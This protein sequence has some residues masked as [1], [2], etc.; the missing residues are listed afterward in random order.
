MIRYFY[1]KDR[2]NDGELRIEYCPT[3]QML[4]DFY[5]KALDGSLFKKFK[6]VIMGWDPITS[7]HNPDDADSLRVKER[8][9]E[10]ITPVAS[11]APSEK[12]HH[13][14]NQKSNV[15]IRTTEE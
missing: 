5:T 8:V 1:V 3:E 13:R 4:V 10:K 11:P 6:R 2:I 7:L 14:V 12:K 15:E 9:G